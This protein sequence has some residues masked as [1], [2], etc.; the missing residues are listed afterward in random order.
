MAKVHILNV[1]VHNNPATFYTPFQFEIHFECLE[2]LQDD[3]EFKII[4]VGSAETYEFDQVLDQIVVDAV[5][6]GQF[7]FMF[8]ADPPDTAKIP[9]D[10][11]V[12]VT[13]VLITA[14]YREQEFVRVGYYVTNEYEDPE[15]RENPPSE[16][17]FDKLVRAIAANEPRVTKFKIN[18]D[19]SAAVAAAAL[20]A[21]NGE[22]VSSEAS[23]SQATNPTQSQNQEMSS[24]MEVSAPS[25]AAFQ[26]SNSNQNQQNLMNVI[27]QAQIT[28]ENK[29]NIMQA[30]SDVKVVENGS[31]QMVENTYDSVMN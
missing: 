18:W 7:K 15:L 23:T 16:P 11:A 22:T 28:A 10:D 31:N 25:A 2:E 29:E 19:S 5:P 4:Y 26:S 3:L 9:A 21:A 24:G 14:S 13:V 17:Q 20:A 30:K 6:Q 12:G 1:T 27:G 8:Q